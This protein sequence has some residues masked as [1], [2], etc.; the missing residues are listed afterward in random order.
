MVGCD[1]VNLIKTS[2]NGFHYLLPIAM[3]IQDITT[4]T[5][6]TFM[7]DQIVYILTDRGSNFTSGFVCEF[8]FSLGCRHLTTTAYYKYINSAHL[9]LRFLVNN[10]TGH[11][12]SI[13]LFG[14]NIRTPAI[15]PAPRTD[16]VEDE[17]VIEIANRVKT[18][19]QLTN[20]L[21]KEAWT[22]IKKR[23]L[24]DKRHY[25]IQVSP[26]KRFLVSE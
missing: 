21:F 16:F 7:Y 25:D 1:A 3:P 14:Y 8:L 2:V 17:A 12:P 23:Q 20:G 18:I 15:W 11:S 4:E 9:V 13:L 5:T 22:R 24:Q 26:C 10:S 19:Q 6:A